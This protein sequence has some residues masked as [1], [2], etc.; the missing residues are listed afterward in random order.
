MAEVDNTTNV[1]AEVSKTD[2]ET[3][4]ETEG[5]TKETVEKTQIILLVT[6]KNKM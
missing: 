5:D 6:M 4:K 3:T 2:A 1:E